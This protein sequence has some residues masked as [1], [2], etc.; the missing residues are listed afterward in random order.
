M[1]G[2]NFLIDDCSDRKTIEAISEGLPQL[3][4]VPPLALVVK[5]VDAIDRGTF[6]VSTQDEEILRVFDFIRQKKA[7]CLQRLL[8]SVH[9]VTKKQVI[10]F[11][12]KSAVFEEAEEIVVLPMNVA[13]D[14][15][16]QR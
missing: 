1:H 2:K 7:D 14:L 16:R 3:D 6:M 10:G 5:S 13:T 4:V 11:R 8:S 15:I 12:G 9:I